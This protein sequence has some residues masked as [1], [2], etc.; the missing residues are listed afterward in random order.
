MAPLI[1]GAAIGAL[2]E[3]HYC[4][5]SLRLRVRPTAVAA[6]PRTYPSRRCARIG[7]VLQQERNLT[8][9]KSNHTAVCYVAT[10]LARATVI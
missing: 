6:P 7:A 8:C 10:T 5:N 9:V 1:L 3:P 2:I 4:D